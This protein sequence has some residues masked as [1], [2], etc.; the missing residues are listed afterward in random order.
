MTYPLLKW[1]Q[2]SAALASPYNNMYKA[3]T[4][5]GSGFGNSQPS[6]TFASGSF[7]ARYNSVRGY[8]ANTGASTPQSKLWVTPSGA[9]VNWNG[10]LVSGPVGG[11]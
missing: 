11:K 8:N 1:K 4:G 10:Q 7:Q 5:N 9:V 2:L 6:A 3:V